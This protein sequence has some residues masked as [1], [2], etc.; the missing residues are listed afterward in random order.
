MNNGLMDK[1]DIG[2]YNKWGWSIMM[3]KSK[4]RCVVFICIIAILG[5]LLLHYKNAGKI[6]GSWRC[7][8]IAAQVDYP[9]VFMTWGCSSGT[10]DF[11]NDGTYNIANTLQG[12]YS[13]VHDGKALLMVNQ[14]GQENY[15]DFEISGG[16]LYIQNERNNLITFEKA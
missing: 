1:A 5:V 7:N 4:K 15:F 14:W 9:L 12:T 16:V 13:I 2:F 11:Y 6:I 8:M 3:K 10:V